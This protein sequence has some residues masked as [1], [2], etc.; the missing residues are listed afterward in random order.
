MGLAKAIQTHVELSVSETSALAE[1]QEHPQECQDPAPAGQP[2]DTLPLQPST[3][4]QTQQT[5]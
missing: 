4:Q 5:L 3:P 2:Y 1:E